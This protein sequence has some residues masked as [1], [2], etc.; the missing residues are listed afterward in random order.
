MRSVQIC[1]SFSPLSN[2]EGMKESGPCVS[3]HRCLSCTSL[4]KSSTHSP[5]P[6]RRLG[7]SLTSSTLL[8]AVS[9]CPHQS[10]S[11]SALIRLLSLPPLFSV[12]S[13]SSSLL[14]LADRISCLFLSH[15]PASASR[16]FRNPGSIYFG[17]S[18]NCKTPL[19]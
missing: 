18:E 4:R 16:P 14:F 7:T 11:P 12:S 10:S 19:T 8:L 2:M 1:S 3:L 15:T 6:V 5:T 13:V 9:H 17:H